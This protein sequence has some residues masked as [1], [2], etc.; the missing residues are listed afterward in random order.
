MI[1]I[2]KTE[3][4]IAFR[5]RVVPRASRSE[6]AGIQDDA[7]KVRITAPPVEGRANEECIRLLAEKLGV[8]KA[9]VTIIAGH[10][11]RAK[12]VAVTGIGI[13]AVAALCATG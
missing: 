8:K 6:I 11:S 12:T 7:L 5:I 2:R 10:S 9:Q 4:G 3:A 13:E 1:P